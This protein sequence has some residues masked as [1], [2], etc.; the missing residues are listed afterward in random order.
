MEQPL[1]ARL[2][3]DPA[4][5]Q[6]E[7]P[8]RVVEGVGGVGDRLAVELGAE[9]DARQC[10]QRVEEGEGAALDVGGLGL[11][12]GLGLGFGFGLGLAPWMWAG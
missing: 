6:L 5:L 1:P 4:L 8:R 9:A 12:L 3:D 11:G 7:Q 2:A 10:V